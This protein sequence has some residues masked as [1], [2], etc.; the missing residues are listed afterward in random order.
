MSNAKG[1]AGA[2]AD[3]AGP[4]MAPLDAT[5]QETAQQQPTFHGMPNRIAWPDVDSSVVST[6]STESDLS[7][8]ELSDEGVADDDASAIAGDCWPAPLEFRRP[9]K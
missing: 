5:N 3:M 8:C 2:L 7:D 9:G 6:S 1:N 4:E